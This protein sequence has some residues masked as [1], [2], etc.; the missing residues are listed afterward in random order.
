MNCA[1]FAARIDDLLDG[2][3]DA[4]QCAAIERHL[5]ECPDCGAVHRDLQHLARL[6]RQTHRPRMPEAV[7][8]RIESLLRRDA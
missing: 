3:L 2:A 7:R 5:A 8:E 4:D 1:D 6:C